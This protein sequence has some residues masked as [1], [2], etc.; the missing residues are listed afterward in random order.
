MS[1]TIFVAVVGSCLVDCFDYLKKVTDKA[2]DEGHEVKVTCKGWIVEDFTSNTHYLTV[3]ATQGFLKCAG[4]EFDVIHA[5]NYN[6]LNSHA[7]DYMDMVIQHLKW[8]HMFR[9]KFAEDERVVKV[10]SYE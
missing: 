6:E 3:D 7:I 10:T 9:S 1:D 2:I 4:C 5:V 8:Y